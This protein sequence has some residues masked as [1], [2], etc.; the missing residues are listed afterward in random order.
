[1][2]RVLCLLSVLLLA[3]LLCGCC[4]QHDMRPATCTEASTCAKC[5]K[6]EG[7]PLGHTEESDPAVEPS[8]TETGLTEGSHCSV[9]GEILVAQETIP[10]LGHTEEADPAVEPSCTETGLTEGSH[11]SVCGEIL[12]AQEEIPALGHT[13]ETDPAVEASCTETGLTEGSHCF[14][15]GDTLVPQEE[16][17]ALGHDWEEATFFQPKTCRRCGETEGRGLGSD[18]FVEHLFREKDAQEPADDKTAEKSAK[19]RYEYLITASSAGFGTLD[20][21]LEDSSVRVGVDTAQEGAMLLSMDLCLNGSD[22]LRVLL[23]FEKEGLSLVLPGSSDTIYT[24]SY[25]DLS[26]LI[27]AAQEESEFSFSAPTFDALKDKIDWQAIREFAKRY[28]GILFSVAN[29]HN[30]EEQLGL[31]RL[32][33]LGEE[34]FCLR[35]SCTPK[36]VDWRAMIS[37]LLSTAE[38]DGE[39][40]EL[41]AKVLRT[42]SAAPG[43]Q[44]SLYNMGF[45]DVEELIDALPL[46]FDQAG[47]NLDDMLDTLDGLTFEAAVGTGRIYA[48]TFRNEYGEGFGYES[49]GTLKTQRRDALVSYYGFDD[50]ELV[51]LNELEQYAGTVKGRLSRSE[52]DSALSYLFTRS[53]GMLN[54]DLRYTVDDLMLSA[55]LGGEADSRELS[56]AFDDYARSARASV[57]RVQAEEPLSF[58]EGERTALHTQEEL[59]EAAMD[60]AFS[61]MGSDFVSRLSQLIAPEDAEIPYEDEEDTASGFYVL[62]TV[63]RYSYDWQLLDEQDESDSFFVLTVTDKALPTGAEL[64][65]ILDEQTGYGQIVST[66]FEGQVVW[67]PALTILDGRTVLDSAIGQDGDGVYLD[68]LIEEDGEWIIVEFLFDPF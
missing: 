57:R 65:L 42:L 22:P 33:G 43:F 58:P 19:V 11:C 24:I 1:M 12:A 54:F 38:S 16:V 46:F 18:F 55:V 20:T 64:M 49:Y 59:G 51:L 61:A 48:L 21:A 34:T 47:E 32:E 6:T 36:A 28:A 13:E 63:S 41:M 52:D 39:L 10:A 4:L 50:A 7:E 66:D 9:C 2:K 3:L 35:I 31:I 44:D 26:A 29:P 23:S 17:P 40:Q 62:R 60:L 37:N 5:G 27:N 56:I 68:L 53:N 8:C 67:N 30:T 15:C 25:K 14:V 45:S